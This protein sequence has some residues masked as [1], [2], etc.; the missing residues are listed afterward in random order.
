VQRLWLYFVFF[1]GFQRLFQRCFGGIWA[2]ELP[3]AHFHFLAWLER[4]N[5]FCL[6]RNLLSGSGVPGFSGFPFFD[7]KHAEITQFDPPFPHQHIDQGIK[8]A[9]HQFPRAKLRKIDLLGNGPDDI[10]FG[11]GS[12]APSDA[13][14]P[15]FLK[16]NK[17][18]KAARKS[19]EA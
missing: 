9:L 1:R 8:R 16:Q 17:S 5:A 18:Q 10:F 13:I 6:Y 15:A 11:H 3:N 12:D 14:P 2:I 7:L 19:S 4:H